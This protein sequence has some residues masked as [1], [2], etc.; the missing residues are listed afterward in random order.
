MYQGAASPSPP[1]PVNLAQGA[2]VHCQLE[3]PCPS[4]SQRLCTLG[5]SRQ[6]KEGVDAPAVVALLLLPAGL[7]QDS[8]W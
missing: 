7:A 8:Q 2:L 4:L 5:V 6:A 1:Q 3:R